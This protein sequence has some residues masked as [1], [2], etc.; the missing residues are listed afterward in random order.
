MSD[1]LS[2]YKTALSASSEVG[3]FYAVYR[4][5]TSTPIA[6]LSGTTW[7]MT[8]PPSAYTDW[9]GGLSAAAYAQTKTALGQNLLAAIN[10]AYA[11]GAAGL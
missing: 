8:A 2:L 3:A 6:T 11:A 7:T 1:L 9:G 5:A 10:A 4:Q